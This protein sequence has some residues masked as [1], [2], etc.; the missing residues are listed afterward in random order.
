M[1]ECYESIL[2]FKNSFGT[3]IIHNGLTTNYIFCCSDQKPEINFFKYFNKC[4]RRILCSS[5]IL[6]KILH[7]WMITKILLSNRKKLTLL[8]VLHQ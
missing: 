5:N 6:H 8:M 4:L 2:E 1:F 3:F 7:S